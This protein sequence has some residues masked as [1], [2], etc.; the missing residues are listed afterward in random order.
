[1]DSVASGNAPL[2]TKAKAIAAEEIAT[3]ALAVAVAAAPAVVHAE[4]GLLSF[5]VRRPDL[6]LANEFE[7]GYDRFFG[8]LFHEG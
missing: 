5:A 1:M 7:K 3:P 8:P 6:I 2:R 4:E